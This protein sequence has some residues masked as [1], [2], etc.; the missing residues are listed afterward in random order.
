VRFVIH[1][2]VPGSLDAYYQE[3]GRAGRDGRQARAVLAFRPQ[4]LGMQRFF[5]SGHPDADTIARVARALGAHDAPVSA[6][7]LRQETGLT[8]SRLTA[9][10]NLLQQVRALRTTD[11][12]RLE[13]L[14]DLSPTDAA[15]QALQLAD[16]HQELERSRVDM[17]RGYAETTGC[18]RRFLLGYFGQACKD[19]CGSCDRCD[20]ARPVAGVRGAGHDRGLLD[21]TS[22]STGTSTD[23]RPA[24]APTMANHPFVPGTRVRHQRW[25]HGAVMSEEEGRLTILFESAGYRTLSLA[26]VQDQDLLSAEPVR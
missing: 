25:G 10:V 17:M 15:E 24:S 19:P 3:I 1:A 16:A 8:A 26:V 5:A 18:R 22:T 23:A 6:T 2:S 14:A 11:Q 4:D 21:G 7:V 13:P 9:V 20:S 12:G